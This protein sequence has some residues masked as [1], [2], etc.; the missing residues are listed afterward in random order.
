MRLEVTVQQIKILMESA[1]SISG[2]RT[3]DFTVCSW[4]E[5]HCAAMKSC[6]VLTD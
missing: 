1:D 6:Q 5:Y 2:D 4:Y 3:R